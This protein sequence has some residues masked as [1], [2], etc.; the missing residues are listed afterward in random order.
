MFDPLG[1]VVWLHVCNHNKHV[2][3]DVSLCSGLYLTRST[4]RAATNTQTTGVICQKSRDIL[5]KRVP[6]SF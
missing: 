6:D 1:S 4:N 3:T 2:M 5:P